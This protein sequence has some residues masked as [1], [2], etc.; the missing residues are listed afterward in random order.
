MSANSVKSQIIPDCTSNP[1]RVENCLPGTMDWQIPLGA[2]VNPPFQPSGDHEVEGYASKTSVNVGETIGFH[3]RTHKTAQVVNIDIYRLGYYAG[4]GARYIASTSVGPTATYNNPLPQ[5]NLQTGLAESYWQQG[6]SWAVPSNAVSGFYLA[7]LTG[8]ITKHQSYISFV[9][10]ND[11]YNSPVL[12]QTA[13]TTHLPTSANGFLPIYCCS[14]N[15]AELAATA[16]NWLKAGTSGGKL[17][18]V[19]GYESDELYN[20]GD[21]YPNHNPTIVV[22][23][24][25]FYALRGKVNVLLG[26]AETTFYTLQSNGAKVFAA[27]GQQWSWGLDDWGADGSVGPVIALRQASMNVDSQKITKNILDCFSTYASCGN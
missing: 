9:V 19:I 14:L 1:I 23:S 2:G 6:A 18:N 7:K 17:Y 12:F 26:T 11:S 24:T 21:N 27:S 5:I 22:A 3:I 16:P 8:S 20:P 13:V 4:N 10:R 15:H 25:P